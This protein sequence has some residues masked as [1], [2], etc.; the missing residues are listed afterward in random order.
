MHNAT[1]PG[2][3]LRRRSAPGTTADPSPM[4]ARC[5]NICGAKKTATSLQVPTAQTQSAAVR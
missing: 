2:A 4:A 3:L 5:L 1:K